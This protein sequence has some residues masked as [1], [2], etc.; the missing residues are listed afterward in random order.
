MDKSP[1]SFEAACTALSGLNSSSN[2]HPGLTPWAF[3]FRPFGASTTQ[4]EKCGLMG[5]AAARAVWWP[6]RGHPQLNPLSVRL[7]PRVRN[8]SPCAN[9]ED[10]PLN[11]RK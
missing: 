4:R 8:L 3:L 10:L 1:E 11:L 6:R 7:K 2:G 5:S 9:E